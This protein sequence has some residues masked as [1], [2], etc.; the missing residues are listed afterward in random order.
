MVVK[1]FTTRDHPREEDQLK[2]KRIGIMKHMMR[3]K[4][5]LSWI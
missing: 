1:M 2:E 4:K 3:M 5:H